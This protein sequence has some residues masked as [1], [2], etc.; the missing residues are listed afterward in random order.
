MKKVLFLVLGAV[1]FSSCSYFQNTSSTIDPTPIPT[2]VATANIEPVL[3][4][5]I[6]N[7]L[8]R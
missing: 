1:L 7:L 5:N 3:D 6:K 8:I 2:P 4:G